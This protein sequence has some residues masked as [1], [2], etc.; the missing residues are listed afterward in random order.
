[1]MM[2]TILT[3]NAAIVANASPNGLDLTLSKI[4]PS[5]HNCHIDWHHRLVTPVFE[6]AEDDSAIGLTLLKLNPIQ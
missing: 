1:M 5:S 2:S 6:G 3:C 4:V